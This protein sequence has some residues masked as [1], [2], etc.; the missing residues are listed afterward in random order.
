M[1]SCFSIVL[2]AVPY[3]RLIR[4]YQV[5]M[6]FATKNFSWPTGNRGS[7]GSGNVIVISGKGATTLKIYDLLP[8]CGEKSFDRLSFW[9]LCRFSSHAHRGPEDLLVHR[10][11]I[12]L[13]YAVPS[14]QVFSDVGQ[15]LI[16]SPGCGS[17]GA[18]RGAKGSHWT[19]HGWGSVRERQST[20][21]GIGIPGVDTARGGFHPSAPG[22][23]L[24]R[25]QSAPAN[26]Y[27]ELALHTRQ[28]FFAQ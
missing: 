18:S 13:G 5:R 11:Q 17:G 2:R 14:P 8:C 6:F 27:Q 28:K 7:P 12:R 22:R 25:P 23:D 3:F 20:A 19:F 21:L 24:P 16:H 9:S 4:R 1:L 15:G 26:V 10:L